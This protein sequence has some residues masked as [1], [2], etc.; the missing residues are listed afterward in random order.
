MTSLIDG[1]TRVIVQGL[2]GREGTFHAQQMIAYNTSVVAG[3]TPG[4]KVR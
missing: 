2:T 4:D 1:R 3:V